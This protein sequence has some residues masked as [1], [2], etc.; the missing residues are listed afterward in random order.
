[1]VYILRKRIGRM[2][3]AQT[4]PSALRT[5]AASVVMA[6]AVLTVDHYLGN[7]RDLVRLVVMI[8]AGAA[9]FVIAVLALRCEE[10]HDILHR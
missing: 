7:A 8:T 1:M 4:I 2:G 3:W 9:T 10:F 5:V 6:A